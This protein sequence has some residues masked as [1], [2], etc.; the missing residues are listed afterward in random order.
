MDSN[1]NFIASM[2][3]E[4]L[5][6]IFSFLPRRDR[7]ICMCMCSQWKEAMDVPCLWKH[8]SVRL[9]VDFFEVSTIQLTIEFCKYIK[10][11]EL[12]FEYPEEPIQWINY[13][14]MDITKRTYR[15]LSIFVNKNLQITR[16]CFSNFC[17]FYRSKKIL[18]YLSMFLRSQYKIK[19]I[20]FNGSYFSKK[21]LIRILASS[22]TA[23]QC[24][25]ECLDIQNSY[26]EHEFHLP[27]LDILSSQ[28]M[29]TLTNLSNLVILKIDLESLINNGI[30]DGFI[31]G[32]C[33][34]LEYLDIRIAEHDVNNFTNSLI[35]PNSTWIK[36]Q[37]KYENLKVSMV[38]CKCTHERS[39][40]IK[41]R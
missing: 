14:M 36:L 37:R 9:D 18:Y 31:N 2:P 27:H 29:I 17:Y 39:I 4:I 25:I 16:I 35:Y 15:F 6:K 23:N 33:E 13:K 12:K 21:S 3:G 32:N 26:Y 34:T 5:T 41:F 40:F 10:S 11:L 1:Q 22:I 30:L 38:F 28:L 19:V 20:S 8:M 7:F 24:S